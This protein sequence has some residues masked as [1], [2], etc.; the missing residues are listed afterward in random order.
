MAQ[1]LTAE[2]LD[3]LEQ[4]AREAAPGVCAVEAAELLELVG[5]YRLFHQTMQ[6]HLDEQLEHDAKQRSGK[7]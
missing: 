7:G 2:Q 1:Q 3:S 4:H 5:I 6:V